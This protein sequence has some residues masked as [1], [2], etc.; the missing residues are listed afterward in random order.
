[1]DDTSPAVKVA[2]RGTQPSI[3]AQLQDPDSQLVR[4]AL[5]RRCDQ[6]RAPAGE[7][8]TRRGGFKQDLL[9]RLIH[10]G[11]LENTDD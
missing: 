8:C 5:V 11:R 10:I 1:M 2:Q 6:C 3:T 7:L 9:G 4:R